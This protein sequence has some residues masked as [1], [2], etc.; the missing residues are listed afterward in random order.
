MSNILERLKDL[1]HERPTVLNTAGAVPSRAQRSSKKRRL[2]P[3][4]LFAAILISLAGFFA[5]QLKARFYPPAHEPTSPSVD[6]A[7]IQNQK[8]QIAVELYLHGEYGKS[9]ESFEELT[10]SHPES[11]ELHINLAMAY[12]QLA[13]FE[14][15]QQELQFA[16][17]K[18]PKNTVALNNLGLL[19]LE[20][21]QFKLAGQSL[22]KA[23]ELESNSPQITLNLASFFEKTGQIKKSLQVYQHFIALSTADQATV[24]LVKKRIPRLSSLS[25][26]IDRNEGEGT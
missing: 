12:Q 4:L 24:E 13:K 15:A 7:Q 23:Y 1:E 10:K 18:D 9:V 21:K 20:T 16:L 8:N 2:T 26:Q 5:M 17:E 19:A 22:T 25:A 14:K 11:V 6:V 3:L